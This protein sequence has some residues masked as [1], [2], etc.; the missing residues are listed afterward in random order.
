[1]AHVLRSP[2]VT[3]RSTVYTLSS[4][5]K[6]QCECNRLPEPSVPDPSLVRMV[7]KNSYNPSELSP[8]PTSHSS[9]G[10]EN[11]TLIP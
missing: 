7:Y 3:L 11:L 2:E 4:F 5:V 10:R 9:S 1:M 8:S 6:L